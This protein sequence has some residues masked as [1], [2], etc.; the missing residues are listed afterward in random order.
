MGSR[1]HLCF[2]S[3]TVTIFQVKVIRGKKKELSFGTYF[4]VA[5]PVLRSD[6]RKELEKWP[7]QLRKNSAK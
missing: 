5:M 6:F 4:G 1:T 7:S 2:I 3:S